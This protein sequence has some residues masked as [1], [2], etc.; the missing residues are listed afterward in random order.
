MSTL[1]NV[2]SGS[3]ILPGFVN[4]DLDPAADLQVDVR[5]GLPFAHNSVDHIVSEH[6]IEHL[7]QA[8]GISF[9]RECRRVLKPGGALR[10]ATPDLDEIITRYSKDW[11]QQAWIQ[12][13][14]IDWLQ[15]PCEMLNVSMRSWDHQ[16]VYNEEELRRL[17][18][19][20]GLV[21]RGRWPVGQSDI[22]ELRGLEYRRGSLVLEFVKQSEPVAAPE[23]LVSVL[24]PA[25]NPRYLDV[26]LKSAVSQTYRR[27]EIIVSDDSAGNDVE[28]IVSKYTRKDVR[29]RYHRNP[30]RMGAVNN[31]LCLFDN[32]RG[33]YVKFLND[34]DML[35]PSCVE[36]MVECFQRWPWATLITSRRQPVDRLGRFLPDLPATQPLVAE[37]SVV[38]GVSVADHLLRTQVNFIGEPSTTLFRRQD[39]GDIRPHIFSFGG[40]PVTWNVDV[41]LWL[42]LLSKG[43][44]IYLVETLSYFRL[45]RE[46]EQMQPGAL[47]KGL[48]A[49]VQVRGDSIR[50][51]FLSPHRTPGLRVG[52]LAGLLPS[53]E[54]VAETKGANRERHQAR[55]RQVVVPSVPLG[56]PATSGPGGE[57]LAR[58]IYAAQQGTNQLYEK[59]YASH[60]GSPPDGSD[61]LGIDGF[62][63]QT[64]LLSIIIPVRLD[65]VITK[66]CLEAIIHHTNRPYEIIIIDNDSDRETQAAIDEVAK[67]G[68]NITVIRNTTNH[69]YPYACNQGIAA[70]R[71][72]YLVVM[73]NDVIVT[74]YWASRLMAA[75]ALDPKVGVVGPRTNAA[76]GSQLVEK[77]DYGAEGLDAWAGRWHQQNARSP[78]PVTRLIAFLVMLRRKLV[79]QIGGFDPLFG[80]GNFEDDDY[81]LRAMLAGYKL[82]VADDVFVHH[83]GSM[84][85]KQHPESYKKLLETNGRLFAGKW[86]LRF[87]NGVYDA[88]ELL[89]RREVRAT[90]IFIPLAFESVFS[91]T[92]V[93]LGVGTDASKRL[94]CIP[95]PSDT[96]RGWIRLIENYLTAFQPRGETALIVRIEPSDEGWLEQAVSC[97]RNAAERLGIDL[98]ERED[99]VVEARNLPS[100]E[101]GRVYSAATVFVPLPGVR[102]ESLIREARACGLTILENYGQDDL[103]QA[104]RD[105]VA[106]AG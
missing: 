39:L 1:L 98:N 56:P 93:P 72:E 105:V 49:W 33:D 97:I 25:Y 101:R 82:V 7:S 104:A 12:D 62:R 71:G 36:R 65:R 24:I 15:N 55:L 59:L 48:A 17:A 43:D 28:K 94:L 26:C 95:D 16:W 80:V 86:S 75:F 64:E 5:N 52:P 63:P 8:E 42:N 96:E 51:G 6:F 31:Y 19:Y 14:K 66:R 106:Q 45:H 41:A 23:P 77:V 92:T 44:L 2:G 47:E 58:A 35:H 102:R 21:F 4:I 100:Q 53:G 73:N 74:P 3:R 69:G 79:E 13:F 103:L 90:R 99:L 11:D 85:F 27:L 81:S 68:K 61:L 34:D 78:R 20:A 38:D 50:M 46:Q 9:L 67:E 29:V 91:P 18:T 76:A 32:A 89:Q 54:E 10:I 37:D 40:R 57:S 22:P 88:A 87:E 60:A 70:A 83:Y 30:K 84:S